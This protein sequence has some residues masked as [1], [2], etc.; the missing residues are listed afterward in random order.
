MCWT[1]G[2]EKAREAVAQY[3]STSQVQVNSQVR[4]VHE[5]G[6]LNFTMIC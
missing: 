2:Y 5:P 6:E 4:E 3:S 1:V